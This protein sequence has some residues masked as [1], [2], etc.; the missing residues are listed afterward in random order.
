MVIGKIQP[1]GE[2]PPAGIQL[3]R[4]F[5]QVRRAYVH[6]VPFLD[7]SY[8]GEQALN[9]CRELRRR[10]RLGKVEMEV[11]DCTV[12]MILGTVRRLD[13]VALRLILNRIVMNADYLA[14][15]E[16]IPRWVGVP[17]IWTVLKIYDVG[18]ERIK[19]RPYTSLYVRTM[20]NVVAGNRYRMLVPGRYARW[21]A[22]E[23]GYPRYEKAHERE[24]MGM[25][26]NVVLGVNVHGH[27]TISRIKPSSSQED[28]NRSLARARLEKD[29]KFRTRSCCTC[30]YGLD[31]CG[32]AC[33]RKTLIK[34]TPDDNGKQAPAPD[35]GVGPVAPA[36]GL[37]GGGA[38]Q[39]AG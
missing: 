39:A 4:A 5:E 31:R 23:M 28:H 37:P 21:A 9:L 22:K 35:A 33:R 26:S 18:Q 30:P 1:A 13:K 16:V 11:L 32:L 6:L 36:H 24:L 2:D 15:G 12:S 14:R 25:V 38:G 20:T 8:E 10:L 34:E 19:D 29:C 17:P 3:K 7:E 27:T